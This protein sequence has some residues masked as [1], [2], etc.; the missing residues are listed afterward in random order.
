[1]IYP[2][3]YDH[4]KKD[5]DP[6]CDGGGNSH[7]SVSG[8][9]VDELP[10][11]LPE[12]THDSHVQQANDPDDVPMGSFNGP[13]RAIVHASHATLAFNSPVGAIVECYYPIYRAV[14]YAYATIIAGMRCKK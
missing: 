1:M 11:S 7:P 9:D 8:R 3:G 6:A 14:I 13:F 12:P 4:G 5:Q 2:I 10:H